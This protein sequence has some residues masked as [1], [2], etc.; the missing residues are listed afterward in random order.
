LDSLP[1]EERFQVVTIHPSL[2]LGPQQNTA[3]TSSNITVKMLLSGE[4]PFAPPIHWR[5]VDVRDVARAHR[6]AL[7]SDAAQ[8]RYVPPSLT[9]NGNTRTLTYVLQQKLRYIVC[10]T[11]G[12]WMVDQ[13]RILRK[14]F[15]AYPV[16]RFEMPLWLLK[17]ASIFDSRITPEVLI[18]QTRVTATTHST[19]LNNN[20]TLKSVGRTS[21]RWVQD[22]EGVGLCVCIQ[23]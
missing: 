18:D 3:V 19:T 6:V 23:G 12:L 10:N 17:A 20:L 11:E 21:I 13:A 1:P 2:V 15:P 5:T 14:H 4:Y 16:P 9:P 7:E 8:G 22:R